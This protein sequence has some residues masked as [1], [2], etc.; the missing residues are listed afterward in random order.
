VLAGGSSFVNR[1][2][3]S[4]NIRSRTAAVVDCEASSAAGDVLED[5]IIHVMHKMMMMGCRS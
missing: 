1:Q 4:I 2:S 5:A 3:L